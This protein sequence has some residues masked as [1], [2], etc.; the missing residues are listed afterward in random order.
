MIENV[1]KL[2]PR[3]AEYYDEQVE[4]LFTVRIAVEARRNEVQ[5]SNFH[6]PVREE[7][8]SWRMQTFVDSGGNVR[9][10][11]ALCIELGNWWGE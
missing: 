5:S 6:T 8:D 3:C 11:G 9:Q 7:E 1:G 10:A 4:V 2:I